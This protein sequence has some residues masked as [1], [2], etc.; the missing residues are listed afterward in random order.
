MIS[1][2][3]FWKTLKRKKITTYILREKYHISPS[4]LT[5]MKNN[6]YLNMR[7]VEDFCKILNCRLEDIA[8]YI[9]DE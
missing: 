7:T 4:I 3:P 2:A 5:R 9:P 1:Y 8:E 6:E